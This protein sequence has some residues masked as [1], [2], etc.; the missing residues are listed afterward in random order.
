[1]FVYLMLNPFHA[2]TGIVSFLS[3]KLSRAHVSLAFFVGF[4]FFLESTAYIN[5]SHLT[6]KF[7]CYS[8]LPICVM[9]LF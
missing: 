9:Y 2:K 5:I 6:L 7:S 1:M 4:F 3:K 8:S